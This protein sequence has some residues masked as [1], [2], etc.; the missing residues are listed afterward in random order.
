MK[1]VLT[2]NSYFYD[3]VALRINHL[4]SKKEI[5]V[6]DCY[7]GTGKIWDYIK[8]HIN[9]KIN[10]VHLDKLKQDKIFNIKIDNMKFLK[11]INLNN[12]DVID[13]DAY[14]IPFNQLNFILTSRPENA[15]IFVTVIGSFFN[16]IHHQLLIDLGYTKSMI[17]KCHAIF[18]KDLFGKFKQWLAFKGVKKITHRSTERKHYAVFTLKSK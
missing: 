5:N 17:N 4:P 14:G 16:G 7:S 6:L 2:D 15:I 12:Y 18:F 1:R 11:S 9:K 13:L 8:N 3:K 10:I